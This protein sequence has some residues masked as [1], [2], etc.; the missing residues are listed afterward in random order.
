VYSRSLICAASSPSDECSEGVLAPLFVVSA[1]IESGALAAAEARTPPRP[2]I[3]ATPAA[4]PAPM[5]ACR[6]TAGPT[7]TR[8]PLLELASG[9]PVA[10]S[11][12]E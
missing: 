12:L 1:P 4:T 9:S 8:A 10:K 6:C 3:A 5:A 2:W 7:L 11:S